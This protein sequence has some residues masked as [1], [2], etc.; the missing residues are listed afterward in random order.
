M[1]I[2]TRNRSVTD[3]RHAIRHPY[4]PGQQD[5]AIYA[6]TPL[7]K[8]ISTLFTTLPGLAGHVKQIQD[9][10]NRLAPILHS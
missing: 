3:N 4:G 5:M 6:N 2:F 1:N 9:Q 8:R 10:L 7:K